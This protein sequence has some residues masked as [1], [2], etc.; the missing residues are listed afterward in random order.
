MIAPGFG[1]INLEDIAA[2]RCFEIERAAAGVAST[3][4]SS[5]TTSTAPR[6]WCSPRSPTRCACVKKELA[7][8]RIVVAGGGAAGTAIVSLLLAGGVT[9]RRGRRPRGPL[10]RR[11][12]RLSAGAPR[13]G[14]GTNP[15]RV[16]GDLRDG[17]AGRRRVHRGQRPGLLEP[18]WI[19]D[20]APD[21]GRL[22]PGQ[23]RPGGRPRGGREVRRRRGQRPL[24]LPQPDQQRARLPRGLPRAARRPRPTSPS[25][26]CCGPPRR[27]RWCHRRELDPT[28]SSRRS[29]PRRAQGGRRSDRGNQKPPVAEVAGLS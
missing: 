4:R 5:T 15:R 13:P 7:D 20:M 23:P 3:S 29:S 6:S 24:R 22:R 27:S 2:P 18:E 11:R 10:S 12:R 17:A 1:G 28:S 26:C 14:R 21:A 19:A 9:R 16:R 25:R 8:V